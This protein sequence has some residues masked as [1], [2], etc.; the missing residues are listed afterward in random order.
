M[1]KQ[2]GRPPKI[3]RDPALYTGK[4]RGRPRKNSSQITDPKPKRARGR[5]RK[6][7]S[8]SIFAQYDVKSVTE[9]YNK[10]R[11]IQQ[12]KN[13]REPIRSQKKGCFLRSIHS[14]L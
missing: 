13:V 9:K 14:L 2:K 8:N 4:P 11:R 5:P 1:T 6:A 7:L 12:K 10:A 3:R